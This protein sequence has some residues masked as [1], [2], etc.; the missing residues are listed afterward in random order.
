MHSAS[1]AP[2][3][4]RARGAGRRA[5]AFCGSLALTA[6]VLSGCGSSSSSGTGADPAGAV[7]A[8]S[9]VYVGAVVRPEGGLKSAALAAGQAFSHQADPYSRLLLV[10]QTPG[11]PTLSFSQDVAPW[12]GPNAGVY[13]TTAASSGAI[14]SLLEQGLLGTQG[15]GT[16]PFGAGGA[17]GALVMDTTD[18]GKAQS[19]LNSQA[20]HAGAHTASYHGVSYQVGTGGV[21]FA[22]VDKLAVI[23]SESGVQ[24]VI[25]TTKGGPSL[26]SAPG[27]AKLQ[28]SAPAG[29]LAHV[30]SNPAAQPAGSSQGSGLLQVLS[31]GRE[32][33]IS[34]VPASESLSLYADSLKTAV[35]TP[36]GLLA[37]DPEGARA[38]SDLPGESWLAAGLGN[39]GTNLA[40]DVA[41]LRAVASLLSSP[42]SGGQTGV[43]S[44]SSLIEGLIAPLQILGA[45]TPQAK[46]DYASWMGSAGVF[47]SG[48]SLLELK[49]AIVIDSKN[50]SASRAA[51]GELAAA[52][53]GR[54][55]Q[56]VPVSVPGT[57]ASAGVRV[58]GVPLELVLAAGRDSSG[59]AKFVL[60]LGEAA[61]TAALSP[62]STLG[63]SPSHKAAEAAL[64]ESTQPNL[65]LDFTTFLALLEGVGLTSD[66]S[67][68][69]LLPYLRS[70]T[71][72]AGGGHEISAEMDRY[73]LVL[74]LSHGAG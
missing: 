15:S 1:T 2:R 19:F 52:M 8:S 25:D 66:P 65:M 4:R 3:S 51:V 55:A 26:A 32:A 59:Q 61:V 69:P 42:G 62:Q 28:A 49:A 48:A 38:L 58:N 57:E 24:G 45:D 40:R 35:P 53:H 37:Y 43:L 30:Y 60:G 7:P 27:Y 29:T 20:Q 47:G 56:V 18:E 39:V 23:G 50:P 72:L 17:Q 11:S 67:L 41:D 70:A 44:V 9:A 71:T 22:L 10:L 73:K 46:R 33:D 34:L 6:A 54:G 14:I 5:A 68:A 74:G 13:V 31:G 64:G 16:Y 12:L 36:G 21:S 63:S